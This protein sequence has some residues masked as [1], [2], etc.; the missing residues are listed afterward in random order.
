MS[1]SRSTHI[2]DGGELVARA[3]VVVLAPG[4]AV[5][6]HGEGGAEQVGPQFAREAVCGAS[7]LRRVR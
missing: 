7:Q 1:W 6:V 5:V 2:D 4:L 3:R